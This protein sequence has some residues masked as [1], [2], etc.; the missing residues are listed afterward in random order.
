MA[1]F[2]F[3]GGINAIEVAAVL[4][5]LDCSESELQTMQNTQKSQNVFSLKSSPQK[6][7]RYALQE[8]CSF[9]LSIFLSSGI[10]Q[11]GGQVLRGVRNSYVQFLC[12][13]LINK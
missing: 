10:I 9:V 2:R 7:I 8:K 12:S 1:L 6:L 3:L 4:P 11:R 5:A 13:T